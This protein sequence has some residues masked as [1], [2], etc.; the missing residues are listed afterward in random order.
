M[1]KGRLTSADR[2]KP[3]RHPVGNSDMSARCDRVAEPCHGVPL[4]DCLSNLA[5]HSARLLFFAHQP[6]ARVECEVGQLQHWLFGLIRRAARARAQ[7]YLV[8]IIAADGN[9]LST[10][11]TYAPLPLAPDS[12]AIAHSGLPQFQTVSVDGK[13]YRLYTTPV[14]NNG[15]VVG[16]LQVAEVAP[17]IETSLREL[18]FALALIRRPRPGL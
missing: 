5:R 4:V 3:P 8:R 14:Q 1:S 12:L 7:G 2:A 17:A 15:H 16:A 11:A 18:T 13:A 6:R 9:V 10:N